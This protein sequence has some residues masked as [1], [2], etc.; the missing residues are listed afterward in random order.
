[1]IV[2]TLVFALSLTLFPDLTSIYASQGDSGNHTND[3]DQ[4][5]TPEAISLSSE[6]L[7]NPDYEGVELSAT[8]IN[9]ENLVF[10]LGKGDSAI[11][12][13]GSDYFLELGI[14][15][16][17]QAFDMSFQMS[18]DFSLSGGHGIR[19][20]D[21]YKF[22]VPEVFKVSNSENKPIGKPDP[23]A[24]Y[25]I[26]DGEV[27]ITFNDTIVANGVG[28]PLDDGKF[29]I[30]GALGQ[31]IKEGDLNQSYPF[32]MNGDK[33]FH[34]V[35]K[36]DNDNQKMVEKD[37]SHTINEPSIK[38][39]VDLNKGMK[40]LAGSEL[41]DTDAGELVPGSIKLYELTPQLEGGKIKFKQSEPPK[42]A[43]ANEFNLTDGNFPITF[44]ENA[45]GKVYRIEYQTIVTDAQ[46][47]SALNSGSSGYQVYN[48]V[49]LTNNPPA[50]KSVSLKF[51]KPITKSAGPYNQQTG[52][53][54]WT[55]TVNA[56]KRNIKDGIKI[57]D[58]ISH[59]GA[60]SQDDTLM[61]FMQGDEA[62]VITP[63]PK[64]GTKNVTFSGDRKT[65]TIAFIPAEGEEESQHIIKYKTK[66]EVVDK[67]YTVK[68]QAEITYGPDHTPEDGYKSN[69]G[70]RVVSTNMIKKSG[71]TGSR[72]NYK[73]NTIDWEF[74]F[75]Q[76]KYDDITDVTIKDRFEK[77]KYLKM[78]K[79]DFIA[80]NKSK[81]NTAS[82]GENPQGFH[83][84]L[85]EGITDEGR[86]YTL[87]GFDL[88][89]VAGGTIDG[90]VT[91]KYTTEFDP[92]QQYTNNKVKN[93]ISVDW[94]KNTQN[95]HNQSSFTSQFNKYTEKNGDK[96]GVYNPI[97]KSIEWYVDINYNKYTLE[98]SKI[99][100]SFYDKQ[101]MSEISTETIKVYQLNKLDTTDQP[102]KGDLLP[103]DAYEVR[104]IDGETENYTGFE[105]TFN[106]T[107]NEPY[108]IQYQTRF[109]KEFIGNITNGKV[110][111]V[112]TFTASNASNNQPVE[113]V[114]EKT[115]AITNADK[116]MKKDG[117]D[118]KNT[119]YLEW[120]LKVNESQSYIKKDS[121][122]TDKLNQGQ[123]LVDDFT[124]FI[125]TD[126]DG[127][128]NLPRGAFQI[129]IKE[130]TKTDTGFESNMRILEKEEVAETFEILVDGDKMGFTIKLLQDINHEYEISYITDI[131]AALGD[132][133]SNTYTYHFKG[134]G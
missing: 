95:Y 63:Q 28:Q 2:W 118:I 31:V 66:D 44:T 4:T 134:E 38:W 130:Y 82:G 83:L 109:N 47:E 75:N 11:T 126:L 36:N 110:K 24:T 85:H 19:E 101:T 17:N 84:L 51:D 35:I 43:A 64:A 104:P 3:T 33:T 100:D 59:P 73:D 8:D 49:T 46:R 12:Q 40:D 41:Q 30:T 131:N 50:S 22:R 20:G 87:T 122:I 57:I 80:K 5:V 42:L 7:L 92:T 106:G 71:Q 97:D 32:D 62:I 65:V 56:D 58:S 61:E 103:T 37:G 48:Q 96:Q 54:E 111:N 91:F 94:T 93:D 1:M 55:V 34:I 23:V 117:R 60:E 115:I 67:G 69:I 132:E 112:A 74:T 16:L 81:I 78:Y 14:G 119:D 68:N 113:S 21:F 90:P 45:N 26:T 86:E 99:I 105:L 107:I 98:N 76:N 39:T 123:V 13:E 88:T 127:E 53:I 29:Q 102:S 89:L 120:R 72:I 9:M 114:L 70:S 128:V 10:Q 124:G 121:I 125:A 77:G 6:N 15:N 129:S 27:T 133:L 18:F 52:E 79:D 25:S 108:R 116:Y